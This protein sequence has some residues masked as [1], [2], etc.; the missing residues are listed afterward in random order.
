MEDQNYFKN[1]LKN[2][3]DDAANGDAIRHLADKGYAPI[4]IRPLLSYP[5]SLSRIGLVMAQHF[6]SNGCI[7]D[8]PKGPKIV[9][10][11]Y[12]KMTDNYG[13]SSFVQ[14]Q[15]TADK[16]AAEYLP[17]DFRPDK[18][19]L[20]GAKALSASDQ[21]Y[22]LDIAWPKSPF[23]HIKNERILRIL[24]VICPNK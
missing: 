19:L 23:Y 14:V 13:R 12:V 7:C 24:S 1:A 15:K 21:S 9:H 3:A 8:S 17:V 10:T 5:A 22:L 18:K 20:Q 2:F 6:L 4:D 11:D 16:P